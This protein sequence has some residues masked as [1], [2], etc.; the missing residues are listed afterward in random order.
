MQNGRRA[1]VTL[2][3]N[4]TLLHIRLLPVLDKLKK[5]NF[6]YENY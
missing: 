1:K 6:R 4:L 3:V 5:V 2:R